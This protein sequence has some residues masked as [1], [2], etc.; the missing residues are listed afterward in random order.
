[1]GRPCAAQ[2]G[3]GLPRPLRAPLRARALE[4]AACRRQLRGLADDHVRLGARR[5]RLVPP[6][7]AR[8]AH[9]RRPPVHRRER[10]LADLRPDAGGEHGPRVVLSA[11]RLHRVRG[12][13]EDD[14]AGRLRDRGRRRLDLGVGAAGA[15][16][17]RDR[18]RGRRRRP[19]DVAPLEP[20]PGSPPGAAHD[21]GLGDRRRPGDRTLSEAGSRPG[22]RR[23]RRQPHLA[24]LDRAPGRPTGLERRLLARPPR[25][26]RAR[27]RPSGSRSGSGSTG[28]G[29]GR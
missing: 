15:D 13:A 27:R 20:G 10:L 7:P 28:R 9:V 8:R 25:H 21:R 12:A 14:G 22:R 18:L 6:D 26:A 1:M 3:R 5:P 29:P 17:R 4:P 16:R 11:G 19:A 24:R 23:Q 2:A